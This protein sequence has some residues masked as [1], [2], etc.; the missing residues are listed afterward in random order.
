MKAAVFEGPE[1]IEVKEVDAPHCKKKEVL[2]KI[3]A[4]AICGTDIRIYY[5]GQKNV[6]PPQII[7][8]EIA[9]TIYETGKGVKG[10]K[11]GQRLLNFLRISGGR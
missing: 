6:T 3:E 11:T 8:H 5:H 2:L 10:Y 9:G 1:K 7:G 4:C